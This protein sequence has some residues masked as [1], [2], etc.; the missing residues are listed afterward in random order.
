METD[1]MYYL[2]TK[3]CFTCILRI[4]CSDKEMYLDIDLPVDYRAFGMHWD[5][6]NIPIKGWY[7]ALYQLPKCWARLRFELK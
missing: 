6:R 7:I 5:I 3:Q 1:D 2:D 4:R